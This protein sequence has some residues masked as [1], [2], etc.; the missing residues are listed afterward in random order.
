MRLAAPGSA[1]EP[2]VAG[3]YSRHSMDTPNPEDH[4]REYLRRGERFFTGI[5]RDVVVAE[6]IDY[7]A[8]PGPAEICERSLREDPI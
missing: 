6:G 1:V 8:H 5:V 3:P 7:F 2:D 4:E